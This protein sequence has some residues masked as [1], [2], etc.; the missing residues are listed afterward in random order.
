MACP[1]RVRAARSG[2]WGCARSSPEATGPK[3]IV[4][5][6]SGN[7]PGLDNRFAITSSNAVGIVLGLYAGTLIVSDNSGARTP[8]L[9]E[10]VPS[11]ANGLWKVFPDHTMETRLTL[12]PG[13]TWHDGAPLTAGDLLFNDEVYLDKTLPQVINTTRTFLSSMEAVDDRTLVIQWKQ[14]Y[15]L[16]D[17]YSPDMMPVHILEPSFRQN[18]QGLTSHPWLSTEYVGT[19]PFKLKHFDPGAYMT[20]SAFDGFV[21]GRPKLDEIRVDFINASGLMFTNMLSGAGD[22]ATGTGNYPRYSNPEWDA[23]ID[24]YA[25]TIPLPERKQAIIDALVFLQDN[26][27]EMSIVYALDVQL[28]AKRLV[29]PQLNPIWTAETWDLK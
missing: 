26:L 6:G 15:I 12:R 11:V 17:I 1:G 4:V 25:V 21:L 18:P 10:A 2:P 22:L 8:R 20:L 3:S 5:I 19:G 16:A 7:P 14:P 24:K 13:V 23:L 29:V 27:M 28:T 9:A